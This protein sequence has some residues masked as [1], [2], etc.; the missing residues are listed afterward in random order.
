MKPK[1]MSDAEIDAIIYASRQHDEGLLVLA[2]RFA[3][4]RDAQWAAMIGEPVAWKRDGS[5]WTNLPKEAAWWEALHKYEPD[6]WGKPTPL[7]YREA[8]YISLSLANDNGV[9]WTVI[10]DHLDEH[11]PC[12]DEVN[13]E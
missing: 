9:P 1:P 8:N 12:S 4:A 3:A 11:Y 2:R 10:A 6:L 13:K 5:E 7:S